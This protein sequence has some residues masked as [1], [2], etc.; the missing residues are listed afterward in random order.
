[1]RDP[2]IGKTLLCPVSAGSINSYE[3]RGNILAIRLFGVA[4]VQSIPLSDVLY[5]RLATRSEV[6]PSYLL[7]NWLN[8]L[9]HRRS[10]CPVYVLQTKHRKRLFLKLDGS[11]HF[12]LRQAI[13][14]NSEKRARKAA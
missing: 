14:R 13:G 11:A 6:T 4:T 9:P 3:L 8:F 10:V 12:K 7:F 5:L 1:M 2:I